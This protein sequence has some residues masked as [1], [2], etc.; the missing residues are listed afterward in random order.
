MR[1]SCKSCCHCVLRQMSMSV[2]KSQPPRTCTVRHHSTWMRKEGGE[3]GAQER[4]LEPLL[5]LPSQNLQGHTLYC[6]SNTDRCNH[7][8]HRQS[9][10]CNDGKWCI[11]SFLV[12]K[13]ATAH[14]RGIQPPALQSRG[15]NSRTMLLAQVELL[16]RCYS[17]GVLQSL[18]AM[19]LPNIEANIAMR[20][21]SRRPVSTCS[22]VGKKVDRLDKVATMPVT[23]AE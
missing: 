10:R 21:L 9:C 13:T 5:V 18:G 12:I 14:V 6:I 19:T 1:S 8:L 22:I 23:Y 15:R 17:A 2:T 11:F 3:E 20:C 4:F 7:L 16:T